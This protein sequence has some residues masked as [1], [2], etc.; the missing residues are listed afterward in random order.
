MSTSFFEDVNPSI[1]PVQKILNSMS[2][3]KISTDIVQFNSK[4]QSSS[5][6]H[7]LDGFYKQHMSLTPREDKKTDRG[8]GRDTD[9]KHDTLRKASP[10]KKTLKKTRV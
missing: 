7:D 6:Q 4:S 9:R 8:T 10:I 3:V 5:I 1:D 2:S